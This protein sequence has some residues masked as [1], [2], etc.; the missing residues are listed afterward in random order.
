G[1]MPL[2]GDAVARIADNVLAA[3]QRTSA[4]LA[5]ERRSGDAASATVD[6]LAE[7]DARVRAVVQASAADIRPDGVIRPIHGHLDLAH[8]L[9]HEEDFTIIGMADD[10]FESPEQRLRLQPALTDVASLLH[11]KIGR[12]SCRE[13]RERM[14]VRAEAE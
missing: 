9:L 12:A 4:V 6:A 5:P 1:R 11:S 14:V 13:R 10:V 7:S 8:V 2:D 3:W